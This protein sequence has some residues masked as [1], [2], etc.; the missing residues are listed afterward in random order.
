[1]NKYVKLVF[2]SLCFCLLMVG[3]T[4]GRDTMPV[5]SMQEIIGDGGIEDLRYKGGDKDTTRNS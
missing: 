5:P 1:M 4:E 3:C 2:A